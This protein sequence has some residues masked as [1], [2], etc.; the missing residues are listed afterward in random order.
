MRARS[1]P[2]RQCGSNIRK[3]EDLTAAKVSSIGPS[4]NVHSI[5][6]LLK[7]EFTYIPISRKLFLCLI[8]H[9]SA[10][11]GITRQ[12]EG[13]SFGDHLISQSVSVTQ[14]SLIEVS[15]VLCS[16]SLWLVWVNVQ[17]ACSLNTRYTCTYYFLPRTISEKF[18]IRC[19]HNG[20]YELYYFLKCDTAYSGRSSPTFW[21][22]VLSPTSGPKSKSGKQ[23]GRSKDEAHFSL[24]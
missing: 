10:D 1:T 23:P 24:L 5:E 21:R 19:S 13:H 8:K 11:T 3:P 2:K 15:I 4:W 9:N 17:S 14:S 6:K 22:N 12:T 18:W 7:S 20:D 16:V